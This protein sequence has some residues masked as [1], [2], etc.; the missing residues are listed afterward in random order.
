MLSSRYAVLWVLLGIVLI[1]LMLAVVFWIGVAVAVLAVIAW[2]NV[3]GFAMVSARLHVAARVTA[4]VLLPVAAGLGFA[5][6]Q[7][8]GLATGT[9]VWAL[10]VALP[11]VLLWRLRGRL[12]S[13]LRGPGNRGGLPV[14]EAHYRRLDKS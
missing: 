10:G 5:L 4:A 7:T 8:G 1:A 6:G 9:A 12:S 14:I 11:Q 2:L 3:I 13:T